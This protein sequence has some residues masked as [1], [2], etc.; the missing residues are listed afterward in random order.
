MFNRKI[1]LERIRRLYVNSRMARRSTSKIRIPD[2]EGSAV[3]ETVIVLA[4]IVAIAL[5]FNSQIRS[6]AGRLFEMVFSDDSV[7]DAL[8]H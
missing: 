1:L 8:D 4:V 7:L 3:I 2:L 5:I 6:F